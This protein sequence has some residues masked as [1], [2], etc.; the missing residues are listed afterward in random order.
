M[1][2]GERASGETQAHNFTSRQKANRGGTKGTVGEGEGGEEEGCVEPREPAAASTRRAFVFDHPE[3]QRGASDTRRASELKLEIA[4][5]KIELTPLS[6]F[7]SILW[8]VVASLLTIV[9]SIATGYNAY[10]N[11]RR[12]RKS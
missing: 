2:K 3:N 12:D 9:L 5:L 4:K 6:R 1:G 8:P 11:S 7:A 10:W